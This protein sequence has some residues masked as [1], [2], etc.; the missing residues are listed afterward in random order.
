MDLRQL[1]YFVA[2]A[3]E[4]NFTRAAE[5]VHISQ[6]GVSAQIRQ[7]ERELGAELFDRSARTATLTVAG[8]AALEHARAALAAAVA[9]GRSV[10]EVTGLIRGRLT[11]GMVTGCTITPLFDALAAFHRAH[12]G[13]ELSLQEDNSDRLIDGVRAA[14]V[15]LALVG[16]A[17]ATPD[18]LDALTIISERLVAAVPRGHPLATRRHLRLRDLAGHPIVCMPPG[19]GLRTVFDQACAAR[20]VQPVVALQASAADAIADLAARGLAVAILSESMAARYDDRLTALTIDDVDAP[21]L[22]AL[23]WKGTHNPALRELLAHSRQAFGPLGSAAAD[24][25]R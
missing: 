19:T 12:P 18:G 10:G 3:E 11:V 22:L 7:L 5:R 6:S 9:V 14:T 20:H 1:E 8:K 15:D 16:T 23:V 2:V 17:T 24:V 4:R 13:V 21:A 25:P